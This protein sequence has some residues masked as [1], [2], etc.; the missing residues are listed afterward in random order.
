M[1]ILF[2]YL[3]RLQKEIMDILITI[4]VFLSIFGA[5]GCFIFWISSWIAGAGDWALYSFLGLVLCIIIFIVCITGSGDGSSSGDYSTQTSATCKVCGTT[6]S[7]TASEYGGYSHKNVKSIRNTN[8]CEKCYKNYKY[9]S[10][11]A[12]RAK[13]YN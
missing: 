10:D 12:D 6:Y 8:M 2:Y 1:C 4:G 9:A 13:Y 3:R 7:Y 5:I 11:A